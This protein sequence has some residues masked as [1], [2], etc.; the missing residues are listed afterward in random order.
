VL[1]NG[2]ADDAECQV[3]HKARP[4]PA[5]RAQA[6]TMLAC[7]FPRGLS[8]DTPADLGVLPP[9]GAQQVRAPTRH[10]H[11][12]RRPID[13][14]AGPQP[15]DASC[16]RV[17]QLQF[18]VR[19]RAEGFTASFDAI[20]PMWASRWSRFPRVAHG[21]IALP[22]DWSA[23]LEPNSPNPIEHVIALPPN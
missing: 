7:D 21:R 1:V 9:G 18:H 10:D 12:T 2:E 22:K 4:L 3:D 15:G 6:S 14:T 16:D 17:T 23:P 13:R 19:D 20:W 11:E 8:S 5:L